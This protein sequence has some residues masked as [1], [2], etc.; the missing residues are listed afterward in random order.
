MQAIILTQRAGV[1]QNDLN[2]KNFMITRTGEGCDLGLVL[3]DFAS[4]LSVTAQLEDISKDRE[5]PSIYEDRKHAY[6]ILTGFM[7]EKQG[8]E[9]LLSRLRTRRMEG[10][11][12]FEENFWK[13]LLDVHD[14]FSNLKIVDD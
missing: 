10:L 12:E 11:D 4:S 2:R 7:G 13:N 9:W 3:L 5:Q 8:H 1:V 6:L 14:W